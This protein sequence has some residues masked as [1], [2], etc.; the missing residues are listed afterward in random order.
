MSY[1]EQSTIDIFYLRINEIILISNI[2]AQE[3]YIEVNWIL[4]RS[5]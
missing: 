2:H 5:K 3:Y 1:A 4:N